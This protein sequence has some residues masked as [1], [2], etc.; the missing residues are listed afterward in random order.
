MAIVI[1]KGLRPMRSEIAPIGNQMKFVVATSNVTSRLSVAEKLQDVL[2]EGRRI[3]R[4]EAERHRR[5]RRQHHAED[6][7]PV[8]EHGCED[9]WSASAVSSCFRNSG[10]SSRV[11][12]IMKMNGMMAQL[13]KKLKC[14]SP[15]RRSSAGMVVFS[16]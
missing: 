2:A 6:D 12:R 16:A 8:L 14:A 15:I 5:H 1:S 7:F 11:R 13:M 10:V 3:D 9:F 4:D